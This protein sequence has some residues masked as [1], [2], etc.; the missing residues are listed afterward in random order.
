MALSLIGY[1]RF[2]A[3]FRLILQMMKDAFY[4]I[5]RKDR[6]SGLLFS[7]IILIP[8]SYYLLSICDSLFISRLLD[9]IC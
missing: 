1:T 4:A 8:V 3:Q 6:L 5:G 2:V 7:M 9:T